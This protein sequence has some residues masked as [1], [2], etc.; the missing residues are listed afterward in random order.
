MATYTNRL[1]SAHVHAL[2]LLVPPHA[3]SAGVPEVRAER[4]IAS[5]ATAFQLPAARLTLNEVIVP[6]D[7]WAYA[8]H[9]LPWAI[10]LA[11]LAG[12]PLRL[13][14]VRHESAHDRQS[15]W[16]RDASRLNRRSAPSY[17]DLVAR[18]I[19]RTSKVDLRLT[20]VYGPSATEALSELLASTT[21][22]AVMATRRRHVAARVLLDSPLD[23]VIQRRTAPILH[24]P[25]YA[26]PVDLTARPSLQ[27]ALIPLDGDYDGADL[28]QPAAALS[29][30]ADGRQT[31][32]RIVESPGLFSCGN[33]CFDDGASE[34]ENNAAARLEQIAAAWRKDLP[35]VRTSVVWNDDEPAHAILQQ[36]QECDADFIAVAARPRRRISR[37]IRPGVSDRLIRRS[38]IPLLI[39]KRPGYDLH[40]A[41]P[42]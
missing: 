1:A 40:S 22:L 41:P 24:V 26:G 17:L 8:E 31:L 16:L 19:A 10:H 25:G 36:A 5:S 3:A 37:L 15:Q 23:A 39:V 7:G 2:N 30:L 4:T 42:E 18:R 14:R 20:R 28:L 27:H 9:A 12:A 29:R 21:D 34:L 32:L 6:L 11:Q 35:R 13:V 38:Q 33:G